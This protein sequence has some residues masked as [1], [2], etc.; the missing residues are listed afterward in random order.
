MLLLGTGPVLSGL[1]L[2]AHGPE[3]QGQGSC[4]LSW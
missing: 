4:V 2:W 3:T 1:S